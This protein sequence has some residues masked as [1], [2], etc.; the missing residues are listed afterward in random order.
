MKH[1]LSYN[2]SIRSTFNKIVSTFRDYKNWSREH[3]LPEFKLVKNITDHIVYNSSE[4]DI[5]QKEYS[6]IQ[7]LISSYKKESKKEYSEEKYKLID[8]I[9]SSWKSL[10]PKYKKALNDF[11]MEYY[12]KYDSYITD[13]IDLCLTYLKNS[14]WYE[15][16]SYREVLESLKS[17]LDS[18]GIQ[19]QINDILN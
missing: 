14:K 7:N 2:E 16:T 9:Q 18:S 8:E 19:N 15:D 13:D 17:I 12:D 3:K 11:I 1:L 6:V 4:F 5:I 10:G